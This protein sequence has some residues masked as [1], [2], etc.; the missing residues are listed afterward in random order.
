MSKGRAIKDN[1]GMQ[2]FCSQC[3]APMICTKEPGC[4]CAEFPHILPVPDDPAKGCLCR[5]CLKG[6]LETLGAVSSE[7]GT[8]REP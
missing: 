7:A 6:K 5:G 3:N 1:D 4:W 8:E 2:T